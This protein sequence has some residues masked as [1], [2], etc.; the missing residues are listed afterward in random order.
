MYNS[1]QENNNVLCDFYATLAAFYTILYYSILH[2]TLDCLLVSTVLIFTLV[3]HSRWA[4]NANEP[5]DERRWR[6]FVSSAYKRGRRRGD[7]E[8]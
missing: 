4:T 5:G 6:R 3:I 2:T 1:V 7:F 8:L